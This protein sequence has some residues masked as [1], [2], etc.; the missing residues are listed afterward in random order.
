MMIHETENLA[1]TKPITP[2]FEWA[3][4]TLTTVIMQVWLERS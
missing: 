4:H 2:R 1:Y 3:H